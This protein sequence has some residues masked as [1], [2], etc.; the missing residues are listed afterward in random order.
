MKCHCGA[1][2]PEGTPFC[3]ACGALLGVSGNHETLRPGGGDVF[4]GAQS[5]AQTAFPPAETAPDGDDPF[6]SMGGASDP[7]LPM[8]GGMGDPFAPGPVNIPVPDPVRKQRGWPDVLRQVVVMCAVTGLLLLLVGLAGKIGMELCLNAV[9]DSV[10]EEVADYL[11]EN[12]IADLITGRMYGEAKALIIGAIKDDPEKVEQLLNDFIKACMEITDED[13]LTERISAWMV[14]ELMEEVYDEA[15]AELIDQL[16]L[17]WPVAQIAAYNGTFLLWG[18]ILLAAAVAAY[19]L[20][21]VRLDGIPWPGILAA[22]PVTLLLVILIAHI[23][24]VGFVRQA[25]EKLESQPAVTETATPEPTATPTVTPPPET[26]TPTPSPT[27]TRTPI[28]NSPTPEPVTRAPSSQQNFSP[29]PLPDTPAPITATPYSPPMPTPTPRISIPTPTPTESWGNSG[30][31]GSYG[32]NDDWQVP[33]SNYRLFTDRRVY[34]VGNTVVVAIS[35]ANIRSGPGM[36]YSGMGAVAWGQSF[37]VYATEQGSTGKDWYQIRVDGRNCWIS[38]GVVMIDGYLDGTVCGFPIV[39]QL[40]DRRCTVRVSQA[41]VR[42]GRGTNYSELT[43]A[44][45]GEEY[46]I[47]AYALGNDGLD[48]YKIKRGGQTGWI[49]SDM[50]Y[51]NGFSGGT[52]EGV[53][54]NP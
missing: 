30:N 22:I 20:L 17:L 42:S 50:V 37:Y 2:N 48:W 53:L 41:S 9:K 39:P 15:R 10:A 16:G 26:P 24:V 1:N 25:S 13:P 34:P 32:T 52:A 7:F 5:D 31:G 4:L 40:T 51:L 54:V 33:D 43:Q 19:F 44:Y 36:G 38:S 14:Q 18:M 28:C 45:A 12:E 35:E 6:R 21:R 49:R 29:E 47:L 8:D 23:D 3:T 46:E 11:G 27:P